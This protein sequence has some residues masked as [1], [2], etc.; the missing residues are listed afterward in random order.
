MTILEIRSHIGM[1]VYTDENILTHMKGYLKRMLTEDHT[2]RTDCCTSK[3]LGCIRLF[4]SLLVYWMAL[5]VM[6][7]RAQV[8]TPVRSAAPQ[9]AQLFI[10]TFVVDKWVMIRAQQYRVI[11]EIY[12]VDCI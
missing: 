10:L 1:G 4:I 6:N 9:S 3:Y 12:R 11:Y 8:R 2:S 5:L 7:Q